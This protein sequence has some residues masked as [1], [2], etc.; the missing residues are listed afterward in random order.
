MPFSSW[1]ILEQISKYLREPWSGINILETRSLPRIAPLCFQMTWHFQQRQEIAQKSQFKVSIQANEVD[2][3]FLKIGFTL[4]FAYM[5]ACTQ[6]SSHG[7]QVSRSPGI[8]VISGCEPGA[9]NQHPSPSP[10]PDSRVSWKSIKYSKL[11]GHLS[12][13]RPMT[14]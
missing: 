2:P 9:W 8:G 1:M 4:L 7:K 14:F 6:H 11:L 12:S 3:W 13:S 5:Y 10:T